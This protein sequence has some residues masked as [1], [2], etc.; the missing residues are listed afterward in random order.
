MTGE[1]PEISEYLDFCLY[2][3]VS[4]KENSGIEMTAIRRW[5]GVSHR[6]G[7]LMSYW[8]LT[9]KVTMISRMTVQHHTS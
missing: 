6:F 9:Q 3:H 8:I 5:V 1:K 4:Y 7:G 2:D